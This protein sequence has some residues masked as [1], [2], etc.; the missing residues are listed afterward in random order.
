MF[1]GIPS[2]GSDIDWL[3]AQANNDMALVTLKEIQES[4]KWRGRDGAR[5]HPDNVQT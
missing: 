2:Q 5:V 3:Y 4:S 1:R